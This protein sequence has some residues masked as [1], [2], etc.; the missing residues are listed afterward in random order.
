MKKSA[1]RQTCEVFGSRASLNKRV[2]CN[3]WEFWFEAKLIVRNPPVTADSII[4]FYKKK[5]IPR[6]WR[7]AYARQ[8]LRAAAFAPQAFEHHFHRVV[9][10]LV[11]DQNAHRAFFVERDDRHFIGV[12]KVAVVDLEG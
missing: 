1:L 3:N 9:D 6:L 5:E 11:F 4:A 7:A 2:N 10:V 12:N 8:S